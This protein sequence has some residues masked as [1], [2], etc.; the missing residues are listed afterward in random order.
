MIVEKI[1]EDEYL[2]WKERLEVNTTDTEEVVEEQTT[3]TEESVNNDVLESKTSIQT[4]LTIKELEDK[5]SMPEKENVI[6]S[7]RILELSEKFNT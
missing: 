2:R 4:L 7:E 6:L 1:E 3:T 5:V